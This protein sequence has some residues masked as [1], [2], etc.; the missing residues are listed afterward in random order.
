MDCNCASAMQL[1][2][3]QDEYQWIEDS[4]DFHI[5]ENWQCSYC[6]KEEKI[7]VTGSYICENP[8]N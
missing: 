7:D 4:P 5:Y 8:F 1:V 6:G 3:T 2:K